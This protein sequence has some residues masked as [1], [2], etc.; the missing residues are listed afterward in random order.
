V[1]LFIDTAVF[2]YA[3]GAEHPLRAPA[4]RVLRA[5]A[6]GRMDAV[7]SVEVIQE[8]VH[9]LM[10]IRRPALAVSMARDAMDLFAPVLP[11]T[12]FV[13][14]RVPDL[15]AQ[16]PG[17]AARDLVH[18]ATCLHEGL[19]QIVSP[20]GG[21]DRLDVIGLRRRPIDDPELAGIS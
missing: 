13:M 18:A 6:D 9:R 2:M 4:Q 3:G 11:V 19:T 16:F 10:A 1:T 15:V 7:T 8:I 12:H 21:F 20:D 14:R 17:L 5:V